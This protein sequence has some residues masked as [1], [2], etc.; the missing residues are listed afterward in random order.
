MIKD[1]ELNKNGSI[2]DALASSLMTG[3]PDLRNIPTLIKVILEKQA[4]KKRYVSVIHQIVE[5]D[6]FLEFLEAKPPEGLD[7]KFDDLW[8]LCRDYPDIQAMLDQAVQ[9]KQGERTDLKSNLV[10]NVHEVDRPA[11]NTR[12][13]G[14]RKLRKYAEENPKVAEVYYSPT[15][16]C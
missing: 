11:G 8:Q 4:W 9:G 10:Y 14:L 3:L 2:F 15:E 12:A 13:C 1:L 16:L 6:S 5:F 7:A